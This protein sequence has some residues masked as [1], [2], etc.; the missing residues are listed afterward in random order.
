MR[1]LVCMCARYTNMI[2]S[3]ARNER[4][5]WRHLLNAN[6]L[7]TEPCPIRRHEAGKF[8]TFF[9]NN[10][11]LTGGAILNILITNVN[12]IYI[13]KCWDYSEPMDVMRREMRRDET[14]WDEMRCDVLWCDVWET[15]AYILLFI[16]LQIDCVRVCMWRAYN[17]MDMD[18][19]IYT[20]I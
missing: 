15:I 2:W 12:I 6:Q 16:E 17:N 1:S 5:Y 3:R 11:Y 14:R 18:I 7:G 4:W 19:W 9:R 8:G 20:A 10:W 13:Q